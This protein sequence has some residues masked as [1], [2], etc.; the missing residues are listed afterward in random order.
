MEFPVLS[1]VSVS[2]C[3]SVCPSVSLLLNCG[4]AAPFIYGVLYIEPLDSLSGYVHPGIA[5]LAF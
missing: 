4:F 5:C 3:L 1:D 2:L